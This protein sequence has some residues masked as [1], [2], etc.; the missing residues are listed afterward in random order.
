M[1]SYSFKIRKLNKPGSKLK[2]FVTLVIDNLVEIHGFKIIEGSN[3]L[4]VTPPSHKGTVMEDGN[5]VE[6]YF[7]DVTFV[8]DEGMEISKEIKQ[9]II[10]EYTSGGASQSTPSRADSAKAHTPSPQKQN[11][12]TSDST[13]EPP[14]ARKPLWGF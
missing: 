8:G 6:K 4:F 12:T 7:D 5:S 3:G 1:F 14:R 13:S 10:S 9:A 2:G 11:S